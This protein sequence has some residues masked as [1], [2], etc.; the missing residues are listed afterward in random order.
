MAK[1]KESRRFCSP[2]G[3]AAD[4]FQ[5]INA[6]RIQKVPTVLCQPWGPKPR[7]FIKDKEEALAETALK[8]C[9]LDVYTDGS[10]RNDLAGFGIWSCTFEVSQTMARAEETNIHLAEL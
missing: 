10:V 9:G 3:K 4:L 7:V 8:R 1:R 5:S 2:I 6:R